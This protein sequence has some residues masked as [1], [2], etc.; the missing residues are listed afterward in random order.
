MIKTIS[1]FY[2][3]YDKKLKKNKELKRY[4]FNLII[5]IKNDLLPNF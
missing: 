3:K 4:V 2:N 1:H 5:G